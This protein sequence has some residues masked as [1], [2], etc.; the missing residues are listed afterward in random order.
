VRGAFNDG[1]GRGTS[2]NGGQGS[3]HPPYP[4]PSLLPS[5]VHHASVLLLH[6]RS[7]RR[8]RRS[9]HSVHHLRGGH[10]Q[11][12]EAALRSAGGTG[13]EL[14]GGRPNSVASSTL[15]CL[16]L[17]L[18]SNQLPLTYSLP[19]C[20]TSTLSCPPSSLCHPARPVHEGLPCRSSHAHTASAAMPCVAHLLLTL[21]A[22][23]NPEALQDGLARHLEYGDRQQGRA[24]FWSESSLSRIGRKGK[25]LGTA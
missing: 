1:R 11:R 4:H 14:K 17:D 5:P 13:G 25:A 16:Q 19:T 3:L 23:V 6:G 20:P 2:A 18:L 7:C 15:P 21:A 22:A 12:H 10:H 8:V 24:Q 9:L